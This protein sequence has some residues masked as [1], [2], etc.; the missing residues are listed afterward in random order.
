LHCSARFVF[1]SFLSHRVLFSF[2]PTLKTI[3]EA[4]HIAAGYSYLATRDFRIE[5]QNPPLI[6]ELLALP[7]LMAYGLP[8]RPDPQ[9]WRDACGYLIGRDLLYQSKPTADQILT[10]SRI[11]NLFL[12]GVLVAL[13][14]W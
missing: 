5:P 9:H 6:K 14:G 3:D 12:G 7:V 1:Y 13:T 10:L 8:F 4:M 2:A 11:P